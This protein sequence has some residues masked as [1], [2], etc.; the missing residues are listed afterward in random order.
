MGFTSVLENAGSWF[1][2]AVSVVEGNSVTGVCRGYTVRMSFVNRGWESNP[3]PWTDVEVRADLHGVSL[4]LRRQTHG[5]TALEAQGL[6]RDLKTGDA[7]F[8]GAYVVEG[9][10]VDIV[11]AWLD[12]DARARLLAMEAPLVELGTDDILLRR[13]GWIHDTMVLA[14][15][16]DLAATLAASLPAAIARADHQGLGYRGPNPAGSLGQARLGDLANLRETKA[17]RTAFN[18]NRAIKIGIA[19]AA[20]LVITVISSV[21]LPILS[22]AAT[23]AFCYYSPERCN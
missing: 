8:D 16:I 5:E 4:E 17:R 7:V 19:V 2:G 1:P 14:G 18:K 22:V 3:N 11:L 13:S 12:A 10:P 15:L 21:V 23:A 20:V 9:A 6:V